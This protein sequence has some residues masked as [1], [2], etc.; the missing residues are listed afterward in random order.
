M[1]DR[2]TPIQKSLGRDKDI[3]RSPNDRTAGNV[4]FLTIAGSDPTGR[5]TCA[6]RWLTMIE[7]LDRLWPVLIVL[8]VGGACAPADLVSREL[9]AANDQQVHGAGEHLVGDIAA[10]HTERQFLAHRLRIRS[11]AGRRGTCGM[12]RNN[13]PE[14]RQH[15]LSPFRLWTNASEAAQV[16][17]ELRDG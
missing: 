3:A 1:S 12:G 11:K 10:H 14:S 15:C 4:V 13:K 7:V 8:W 6:G 2:P 5:I 17:R 16:S 9:T